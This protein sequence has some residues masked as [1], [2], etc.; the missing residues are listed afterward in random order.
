[1]TQWLY[2]ISLIVAISGMAVIDRR[3]KL[4]FWSDRRRTIITLSVAVIVFIIWDILGITLGI[5]FHGGSDITLPYRILPEFPVEELF[6]LLLLC[7]C[8]LVIYRGAST[9]WPRT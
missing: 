6:F 9:L 2:L 5:F 8:T 4:A 7:Y 3:Y 1:M